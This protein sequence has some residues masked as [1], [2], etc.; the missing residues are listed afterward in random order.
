MMENLVS[1]VYKYDLKFEVTSIAT[2]QH[3]QGSDHYEGKGVD[4]STTVQSDYVKMEQRFDK[5]K[6]DGSPILYIQCE[7]K[8]K[9]VDCNAGNVDHLHVSYN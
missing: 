9:K 2:G 3:S 1:L 5:L 7:H 6:N 8:G 4:L